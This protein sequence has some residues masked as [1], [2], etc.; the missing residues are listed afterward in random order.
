MLGRA[1]SIHNIQ[2]EKIA[3]KVFL[4]T[5]QHVKIIILLVQTVANLKYNIIRSLN[6]NRE[7]EFFFH[8]LPILWLE[9]W[10]GIFIILK[11][12]LILFDYS[13]VLLVVHLKRSSLHIHSVC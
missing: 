9:F 10:H 5:N 12:L 13:V 8:S 11:K 1:N 7:D 4:F 6:I 3:R 2:K